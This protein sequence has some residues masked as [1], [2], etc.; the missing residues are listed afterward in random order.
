MID[1]QF[2][3]FF[4]L[5]AGFFTGQN[6]V[7][8]FADGGG[9]LTAMFFNVFLRFTAFQGGKRSRQYERFAGQPVGCRGRLFQTQM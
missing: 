1:S 7:G 3:G 5:A 9:D 6:K 4:K 8:F 2:P